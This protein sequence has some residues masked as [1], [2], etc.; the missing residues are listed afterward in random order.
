MKGSSPQPVR[1]MH[2]ERLQKTIGDVVV[3][4]GIDEMSGCRA[5]ARISPGEPDTGYVL[6]TPNGE[7]F[8]ATLDNASEH[9]ACIMISGERQNVLTVEHLFATLFANEITNAHIEVWRKPSFNLRALQALGLANTYALPLAE[10]RETSL[11][12]QIESIGVVEQD[13]AQKFLSLASPQGDG[14]LSFIP[15]EGPLSI[16]ATTN[17][18][19]PG[20]QKFTLDLSPATYREELAWSRP[21]GKLLKRASHAWLGMQAFKLYGFPEFGIGHGIEIQNFIWH[22]ND[23]Q[24]WDRKDVARHTC[25]D[26]LGAIALLDGRLTNVQVRAN[27]SGHAHDLDVLRGIRPVLIKSGG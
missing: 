15:R 7:S 20:E 19:V 4:E 25:V 10:G 23:R 1:F 24:A 12:D 27:G 9:T 11:C 18:P 3:V 26:R 16:Q 5:Y 21:Y 17:Y 13:A 8:R 14:K 2:T 22:F 6:E